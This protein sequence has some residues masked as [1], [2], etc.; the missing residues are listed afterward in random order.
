MGE[1]N[2]Y[3]NSQSMEVIFCSAIRER[4]GKKGAGKAASFRESKRGLRTCFLK[5]E[6]VSSVLSWISVLFQKWIPIP[7]SEE[8]SC[9]VL[10]CLEEGEH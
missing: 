5:A 2:S 10:F 8:L 7:K 6:L 9:A 1:S 3:N 4:E